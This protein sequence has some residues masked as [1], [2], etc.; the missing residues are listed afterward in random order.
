MKR[1]FGLLLLTCALQFPGIALAGEIQGTVE[2]IESAPEIEVCAVGDGVCAAP[3]A[4]GTYDL[5]NLEAG[6]YKIEFI[7]TF[8]LRLVPQYY[9]QVEELAQAKTI[10]LAESSVVSGVDADLK[11]GGVVEGEVMESGSAMPLAE[12]EVCAESVGVP[13]IRSCSETDGAGDYELHSLPTGAY[14][15]GFWGAGVSS[16]YQSQYYAGKSRLIEADPISVT[17]GGRRT[18]INVALAKG[19][20]IR[21][22]VRAAT[23]GTI[24]NVPV[25][26]FEAAEP[27]PERCTDSG[28]TGSY[29]FPGLSSGSYQVGFS[30]APGELAGEAAESEGDEFETQYYDLVGSR[31]QA[32]SISVIAPAVVDGI[33]ASLAVPSTVASASPSP[34]VSSPTV[35]LAPTVTEP[36]PQKTGCKTGHRKEKVKGK[37]RCVKRSSKKHRPSKKHRSPKKH[38]KAKEKPSR[39][40]RGKKR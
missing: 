37:A 4:D 36:K 38:R 9:D 29:S 3:E 19:A 20:E 34:L 5:R 10:K 35:P 31:A 25:C 32:A 22:V 33:D 27:N 24:S 6:S 8:R 30:L 21:G 2:P 17:T 11:T 28:E 40:K 7:P 15:I 39:G 23:G 1:L 16:G 18:G 26:L 13:T 14:R 12:V